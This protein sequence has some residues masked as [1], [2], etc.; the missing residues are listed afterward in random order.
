ML[1]SGPP[2][3]DSVAVVD[4]S[5]RGIPP[6]DNIVSAQPLR[7]FGAIFE[8]I[9][10]VARDA[11]EIIP[12]LSTECEKLACERAFCSER[13]ELEN[14]NVLVEISDRS[15]HFAVVEIGFL[16]VSDVI[17]VDIGVERFDL[18][19]Q[20]GDQVGDSSIPL[21]SGELEM[22]TPDDIARDEERID[23]LL[24]T[25]LRE[26]GADLAIEC[27]HEGGGV[28]LLWEWEDLHALAGDHLDSS[29]ELVCGG[30]GGVSQSDVCGQR[31]VGGDELEVVDSVDE[32]AG[33]QCVVAGGE[34]G[35][36]FGLLSVGLTPL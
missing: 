36:H 7:Q 33:D 16:A 22:L 25:L 18:L 12:K 26:A 13:G 35:G 11:H 28:V 17:I 31:V 21:L 34:G 15:R 23:V 19:G 24:A 3:V 29:A 1:F 6:V 30:H 5:G 9:G 32:L 8:M 4:E 2:L 10:D 14:R 20:L 27:P